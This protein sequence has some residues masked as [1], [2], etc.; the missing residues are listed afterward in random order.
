MIQKMRKLMKGPVEFQGVISAKLQNREELR[1]R[2][3][4]V[5]SSPG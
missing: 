3:A 4:V 2:E 5:H 1:E